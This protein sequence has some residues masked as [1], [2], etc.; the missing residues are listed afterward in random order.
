M[1]RSI[2]PRKRRLLTAN[3][4]F[5][6]VYPLFGNRT[7]IRNVSLVGYSQFANAYI[8]RDHAD[9]VLL[10]LPATALS[11][12][13]LDCKLLPSGNFPGFKYRVGSKRPFPYHPWVLD[14]HDVSLDG[15]S[16]TCNVVLQVNDQGNKWYLVWLDDLNDDPR[17]EFR[18]WNAFDV[19][20]E[21]ELGPLKT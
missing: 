16:T 5:G 21:S 17:D 15:D 20:S 7:G 13:P 12:I 1:G 10:L 3:L 18:W 11:H 8:V 9:D 2:P 6:T 19:R 4:D 14:D